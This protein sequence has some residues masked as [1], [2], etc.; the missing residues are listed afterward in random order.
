MSQPL[1]YHPDVGILKIDEGGT[2]TTE[3]MKG[4]RLCDAGFLH[5][6]LEGFVQVLPGDGVAIVEGEYEV[7]VI[8]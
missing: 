4:E 3:A 2:G 1:L 5:G 7:H 6:K 8:I